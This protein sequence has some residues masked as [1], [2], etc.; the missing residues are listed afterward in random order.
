MKR[1]L[2][3][4][5]VVLGLTLAAA[6][7]AD[8]SFVYTQYN[9]VFYVADPGEA[10]A[11]TMQF[12]FKTGKAIVVRDPGGNIRV[13]ANCA[14]ALH[15]AVCVPNPLFGAPRLGIYTYD[16]NDSVTVTG[17]EA[18]VLG[19]T[20]DDVLRTDSGW[21]G[22]HG[23]EG[24]DALYGGAGSDGLYGGPGNDFISGGAGED[25][26][27]GGDGDDR[28]EGGQGGDAMFGGPGADV[29]HGGTDGE[30]GSERTDFVDYSGMTSPVS[31]T[32]NGLADDGTAAEGDNVG[33]D[34]EHIRG[35]S[36]DDTLSVA[37]APP[38]GTAA[39]SF[40]RFLAGEEGND[41]L[42]G[43]SGPDY[44]QADNG[45]DTLRGNAGDDWL[46]AGFGND[47]LFA[48]DGEADRRLS[49]GPGTDQ[50]Q[51]DAALDFV[52]ECETLLP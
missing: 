23:E 15:H 1:A 41:V 27:A 14:G 33:A 21:D 20:G 46:E 6:T 34:V 10:N 13:G 36:G 7:S 8:A 31:V 43:G 22:L 37:D 26:M 35:G 4:S 52:V 32:L 50:A 16:R 11:V 38:S 39:S 5:A 2:V 49:C 30:P 25:E 42:I 18:A 17:G 28:F 29:F 12:T 24:N 19:G 45:N 40:S 44:L 9:V 51:I 47:T 3:T 48:R